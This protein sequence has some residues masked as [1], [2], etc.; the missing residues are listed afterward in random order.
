MD[1]AR[2]HTAEE[3]AAILPV[4]VRALHKWMAN[5]TIKAHKVGSLWMI[6]HSEFLRLKEIAIGGEP[7]AA[8]DNAPNTDDGQ[9]QQQNQQGGDES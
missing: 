2:A 9:Y 4:T 1:E 6:P 7:C 5:G 3:V 8:G